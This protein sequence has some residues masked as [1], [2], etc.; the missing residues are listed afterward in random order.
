MQWCFCSA[1]IAMA[2]YALELRRNYFV[3]ESDQ[4]KLEKQ[5]IVYVIIA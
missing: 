3:F 4:R 2:A 1:G 5:L